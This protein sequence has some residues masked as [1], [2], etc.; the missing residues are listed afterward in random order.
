[1]RVRQKGFSI[2]EVI[3]A[4]LIMTVGILGVAGLQVV[5]LQ[6]NRSSLLRSEALQI[7]N[8][9]LDRMRANPLQPYAPVEY[10]D[11]P[12]AGSRDCVALSCSP[13][14]METY[15]IAQ[16]KCGINPAD[17]SGG[18]PYDICTTFGQ[19]TAVLPGGEGEIKSAA[20]VHTIKVR[21][22]DDRDGGTASIT[23]STR[24]D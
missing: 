8:D 9:I 20:G 5:S 17:P 18:L 1:M 19:T 24:T 15:D 11:A 13:S 7:G 12:P 21:W 2:I 14:Q 3:I 6:Q 23:L 10:T 22:V 16:W 4:T